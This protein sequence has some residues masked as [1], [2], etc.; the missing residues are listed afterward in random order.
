MDKKDDKQRLSYA[1]GIQ[2]AGYLKQSGFEEL[3]AEAFSEGIMDILQDN[4][5]QI[6][7]AEVQ[8]EINAHYAKFLAKAKEENSEVG[9]AFLAENKDK[10]GVITLPSGLQYRVISKGDED[11]PMPKLTDTVTT[12]YEGKT[13]DGKVF[14][15][16]FQRGEP[17]SFPVNG[18]IKGWTEALQLMHVGDKFELFV[19]SDLA[20]G[21][22]G[23]GAD[24]APYSTLIFMVELIK[25]N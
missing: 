21:E 5:L 8:E 9:N 18:V 6:S 3:E 23:A 12:N 1:V 10:E 20:Y 22:Q 11:G 2:S 15:S 13:I 25:I 17:A 14:D 7:F 19:P 4:D 16:S 24:I